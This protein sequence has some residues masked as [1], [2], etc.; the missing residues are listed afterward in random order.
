MVQGLSPLNIEIFVELHVFFSY[1]RRCE[2]HTPQKEIRFLY[3]DFSNVFFQLIKGFD[4]VLL[5]AP[6]SG[7]GVISKDPEVKIS[8]ELCDIQNCSRLQ[9]ELLLA[10]IDC[11]DAKSKTGGYVVYCTCSVL[12]S[13]SFYIIF[14]VSIFRNVL[15]REMAYF[16]P[17][18]LHKT[19][20]SGPL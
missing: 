4:R 2:K 6:C 3:K 5:D 14:H 17:L 16:N 8:K 12:V 19:C 18:L 11:C 10:A 9:K 15:S 7:T 13:A 20:A 1:I